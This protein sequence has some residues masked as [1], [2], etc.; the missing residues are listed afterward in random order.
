MWFECCKQEPTYRM[1]GDGFLAWI[2]WGLEILKFRLDLQSLGRRRMAFCLSKGD[3][4]MIEHVFVDFSRLSSKDDPI[5]SNGKTILKRKVS[6]G[7]A[8][9]R[10][11][12]YR[13]EMA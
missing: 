9:V 11:K 13:A 1:K 8:T 5:T 2:G 6:I 4:P 10:I 7:I 12:P 3:E